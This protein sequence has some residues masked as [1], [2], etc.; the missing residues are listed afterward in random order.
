[1]IMDEV[2][3]GFRIAPGGAQQF[4][5]V[6]ADLVTYAKAM[7]NGF[8]VGAIAG[9]EEFMMTIEPGAVAHGGTYCGNVL[10][11][12]ACDA[13]LRVMEEEPVFETINARGLRLMTGIHHILDRFGIPH[14][15]SGTPAMFGIF[16]GKE[17]TP[18][19]PHDYRSANR[20]VDET[21]WDAIW[22]GLYARGI[23]PEIDYEEPW[24]LCYA[25]SEADVDETLQ[26]FEDAVKAA[27]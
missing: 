26:A 24:F 10:A 3:T 8:P 15:L 11:A 6:Q 20:Y 1:M 22:R 21:L 7:G 16:I 25:L 18:T 17:E 4:F 27:I 13:T 9:K 12:A 5:G 14:R 23:L 19:P 2:K